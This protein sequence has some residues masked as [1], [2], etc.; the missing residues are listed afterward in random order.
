MVASLD[1]CSEQ[2]VGSTFFPHWVYLELNHWLGVD[3]LLVVFDIKIRPDFF[4]RN[5]KQLNYRLVDPA[6][7]KAYQDKESDYNWNV[8]LSMIILREL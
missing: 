3:R 8:D 6:D 5:L 7:Y 2:S 4:L 1:S